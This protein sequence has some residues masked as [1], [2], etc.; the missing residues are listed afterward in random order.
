MGEGSD[1]SEGTREGAKG[2]SAENRQ[3][4]EEKDGEREI[5]RKQLHHGR[6]GQMSLLRGDGSCVWSRSEGCLW[7]MTTCRLPPAL[8][9]WVSTN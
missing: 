7:C 6:E 5:V 4:A 1:V 3:D 8:Y 9:P 2:C